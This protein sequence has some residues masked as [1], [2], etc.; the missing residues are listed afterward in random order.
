MGPNE[1]FCLKWNDFESNI[2]V[3]FRDIREEREFFDVTL[4]C[5]ENNAQI[6]AHKVILGACSPFFRSVLKRN[7][8][9]KHPLLF[10]KGI[11]FTDL[12]SVLNFMYHGEVNVAQDQLNSFLQVAEDLNVKG[13]TQNK[14]GEKS[15][16]SEPPPSSP[17]IKSHGADRD[18]GGGGS[19]GGGP[20]V[21][22]PRPNVPTPHTDDQDDEIQE[23]V[24]VKSE[25]VVST[26]VA[27]A[28][29]PVHQ[30]NYQHL[31][32]VAEDDYSSLQEEYND[33]DQYSQ[34]D[35]YQEEDKGSEQVIIGQTGD[36][37]TM[38][39]SYSE[40]AGQGQVRC[41]LCG[42]VSSHSGNARQHFEAHHFA[43]P[44]PQ[45]CP[46]CF[47]PFRTKH[48]LSTHM[49]KTHRGF[50]GMWSSAAGGKN[51]LWTLL[52][53]GNFLAGL[54][55]CSYHF[56]STGCAWMPFLFSYFYWFFLTYLGF[57]KA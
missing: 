20:P 14:N 10:L 31:A 26:P 43:V 55:L 49:S 23:F 2:S 21:K 11:K 40:P 54:Q 51:R 53:I 22:R 56:Y 4:V 17:D 30:P 44:T 48:S 24:P 46:V 5:E 9:H 1:K 6:E 47:K 50:K 7:S 19:G 27:P 36:L 45:I 29:H 33:Y 15:S 42:K 12:E 18:P 57:I 37:N 32:L 34:D 25:P 8:Q 52:I 41:T 28:N 38:A 3:A 16:S 35:S 13:L 39:R